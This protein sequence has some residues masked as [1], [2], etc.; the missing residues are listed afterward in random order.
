M[1]YQP[2]D[3]VLNTYRIEE[4]IGEGSF[5]EV[6]RVTH[7]GLKVERAIKVLK[8]STPGLGS[9]E[10]SDYQK[11]FQ[12]EAQLGAELNS[13]SAHSN[14]L[15]VHNFQQNNDLLVLE[16]EYALGGSLA[17]RIALARKTGELIPIAEVVQIGVDVASGL[18]E[19]HKQGIVHRDL[20]PGNILL[21]RKG[22]AKLGDLGLAQVPGGPS[23]RSRLS[24]PSPHPG[25]PGYMSPEQE[26]TA[27]YLNP[28][29][30]VFAL[31][32]IL[33]ELLTGRN[34]H[35][36]KPGTRMMDLRADIP[37]WV[38]KILLRMVDPDPKGR[39]WDGDEIAELLRR[40]DQGKK[41]FNRFPRWVCLAAIAFLI[42][43]LYFCWN[44]IL[45]SED[46]TLPIET[47]AAVTN[48]TETISVP[49]IS[50][51]SSMNTS[52]HTLTPTNVSPTNTI[53]S[54]TETISVEVAA[55]SVPSLTP[56][57]TIIVNN[58]Q[59]SSHSP[60]VNNVFNTGGYIT[61]ENQSDTYSIWL[62]HG[63]K[64]YI[65]YNNCTGLQMSLMAPTGM[66]VKEFLSC[67]GSTSYIPNASGYYSL[68]ISDEGGG[69]QK[70]YFSIR[71]HYEK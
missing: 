19:L 4:L 5:G 68:S 63:N 39:P 7:L 3:T 65:G 66:V 50:I 51:P 23:M 6:Y 69:S 62:E 36:V 16:M 67:Y 38:E 61:S 34:Y 9:T 31:G 29:S 37:S 8:R 57:N 28:N 35:S 47:K 2:R 11:R 58:T 45:Q 32:L 27:K 64:Y 41:C 48:I 1:P 17:D 42:T 53:S 49:A 40:G 24:Q 25:T 52:T 15:Q 60:I 56:S 18:A 12:M 43:G 13:P 21:D 22:C 14:L 26:D 46:P 71:I 55:T 10:Y 59:S 20:K 54:A 70:A 33:F 30:D 44:V